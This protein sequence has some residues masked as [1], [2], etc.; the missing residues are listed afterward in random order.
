M[1]AFDTPLSS[2][3]DLVNVLLAGGAGT[4]TALEAAAEAGD[5]WAFV[6]IRTA[7]LRAR[8]MRQ[9]PWDCFIELSQLIGVSE[10]TEIAA[11]VRL[12]GEQ[13]ARIKLS[14]AAQASSVACSSDGPYRSR[15]PGRDRTD[16]LAHRVDVPGFHGVAG[17]PSHAANRPGFLIRRQ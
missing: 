13:G 8:T 6:Q 14:L 9:T 4:E 1:T 11:S 17:L 10:L 7:L 15:R 2:Y 12:A 5:G 3:L 16:G